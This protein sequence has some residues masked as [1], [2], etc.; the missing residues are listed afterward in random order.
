MLD[1]GA[2]L[3]RCGEN[4][5]GE[6]HALQSWYV[7]LGY[8]IANRQP[9][10]PPHIRDLA[11]RRRLYACVR[12]AARGTDKATLHAMLVLLSA[13]QHLDDLWR[14]EAHL[15]ERADVARADSTVEGALSYS[16]VT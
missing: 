8:A 9:A 12:E 1:G 15:G 7:T 4:L 13:S 16:G 11:G 6:L 14:L 2:L 10:P 3:A 5:D